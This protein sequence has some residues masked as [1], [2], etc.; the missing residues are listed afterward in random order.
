MERLGYLVILI[1]KVD[2][3]DHHAETMAA[4]RAALVARGALA[5]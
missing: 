5:A 4:V 3:Y 1:N 2:Y